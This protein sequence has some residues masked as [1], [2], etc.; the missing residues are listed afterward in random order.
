MNDG[1]KLAVLAVMLLSISLVAASLGLTSDPVELPT[2]V[3]EPDAEAGFFETL[4]LPFRW[5]WTAVVAFVQLMTFQTEIPILVNTFFTAAIGVI[6]LVFVVR[7]IRG[8]G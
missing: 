8:G 6:I 7:I 3:P 5:V 1:L 4:L 2:T